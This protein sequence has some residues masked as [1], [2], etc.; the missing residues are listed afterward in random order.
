[1]VE[2]HHSH[3]VHEFGQTL[4]DSEGQGS[5][6]AAVKELDTTEKLNSNQKIQT[7]VIK[8]P[9]TVEGETV[10]KRYSN[11]KT[12]GFYFTTSRNQSFLVLKKADG[13]DSLGTLELC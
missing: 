1:M 8:T 3:N 7:D 9:G 4:G 13:G 6:A 12:M 11:T 2:Q 5:L 10:T